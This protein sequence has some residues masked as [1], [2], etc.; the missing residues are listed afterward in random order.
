MLDMIHYKKLT[1]TELQG[2]YRVQRSFPGISVINQVHP[3]PNSHL[4]LLIFTF[5]LPSTMWGST[6]STMTT[7]YAERSG[8]QISAGTRELFPL[9]N[10]QTSSSTHPASNSMKIRA[11]SQAVKWPVQTV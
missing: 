10:M 1:F 9:Q 8:F 4:I 6:V 11:L 5:A 3:I 2:N 7:I